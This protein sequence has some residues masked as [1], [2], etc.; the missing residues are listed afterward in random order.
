MNK[1][2]RDQDILLKAWD[3]INVRDTEKAKEYGDFREAMQRAADM[4]SITSGKEVTLKDMFIAMMHIKLKLRITD[5]NL[6]KLVLAKLLVKNELPVE[7]KKELKDCLGMYTFNE[8][9]EFP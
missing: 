8:D 5:N 3:I 1:K 6:T 9:K 4:A 7:L 2:E